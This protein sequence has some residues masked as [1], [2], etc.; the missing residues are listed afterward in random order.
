M[1]VEQAIKAYIQLQEYMHP[2]NGPSTDLD[3]TKNSEAY[4]DEFIKILRSVDMEA[5]SAMQL[6]TTEVQAGQT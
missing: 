1:T 5:D 3:R 2:S 4:R 6:A